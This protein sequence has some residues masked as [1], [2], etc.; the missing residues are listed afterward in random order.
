MRHADYWAGIPLCFLLTLVGLVVRVFS[1]KKTDNNTPQKILFI[2]PSEKGGILLSYPLIRQMQKEYPKAEI[3]FLTFAVNKSLF[4][5]LDSVPV[6]NILTIRDN[7]FH[8]F[9]K[10]VVGILF[11]IR[12]EKID[13]AYDLEFFS[14][15]TAIVSYL[16]GASKRIGFDRYTFEGL[17][18]GGLLTHK[19][20]YNPHIHIAD[21]FLS[22]GQV[23]KRSRKNTPECV[24]D[25]GGVRLELPQFIPTEEQRGG[26]RKK[27]SELRAP[28]DSKLFLVNPGEGRIPLREWPLDNFIALACRLLEKENNYIVLVGTNECLYNAEKLLQEVSQEERC[29]DLSG[30]TSIPELVT[31]FTMADALITNDSGLAH[32]ASLTRIQQFVFFGPESPRVFS[33]LGDNVNMFYSSLPCSPCLS[34][35]NHRRSACHDN[36]CLQAIDVQEVYD[37]LSKKVFV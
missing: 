13:V 36:K 9:I 26:I 31:L 16:S 37:A 5:V 33:P 22:M 15:F 10:D 8:V 27:L 21:L 17:Y 6:E 35:Y 29:I 23:L 14:R 2:K 30:K 11:K 25:P 7:S 28:N 24:P 1:S 34:A 3:F 12:K 18:R 19:V 32:L 4:D 20:Q